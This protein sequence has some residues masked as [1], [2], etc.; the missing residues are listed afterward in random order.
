MLSTSGYD[1][2]FLAKNYIEL[3]K[4]NYY[5]YLDHWSQIKNK[6]TRWYYVNKIEKNYPTN[7]DLLNIRR[8]N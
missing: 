4:G 7:Y 1:V 2:F 8:N 6:I 5:S 3:F